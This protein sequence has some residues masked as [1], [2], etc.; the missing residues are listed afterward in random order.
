[1]LKSS[2]TGIAVLVTAGLLGA[3]QVAS[4]KDFNAN[5]FF[6]DQ[7]PLGK[8]GYVEWAKSLD[9]LSN[10]N[11]KAKVYTGTVLLPPRSSLKGVQDGI[12][13]VGYHAAT[14]TPAELP[15]SNA[16]Q[17]MGLN[18]SDPLVMIAAATDFNMNNAAAKK[19]WDKAGVVYGGGYS[20]PPYSLMCNA[21]IKSLADLKGKR[22]R[23][24]GAAMSRW[25]ESIGAVPVNVPS[26]EMYQGIEKGVLDCAVNVASDLKSRS[27]WDVAKH[28]TLAP[29]GLYWS[30]PM[31]AYNKSFWNDLSA[32]E[33]TIFFNAAAK[34]MAN[35]YV[36]YSSA[37]NT[38]LSEAKSHGVTVYQPG[39]DVLESIKSFA[40]ENLSQVYKTGSEKYGVKDAET[41]LG[42]FDETVK[43]WEKLFADVDRKDAAAIEA[44]IKANIYDRIDVKAYGGQS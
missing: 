13:S 28:T 4:A 32:E 18:Y 15:I 33:R 39:T 6:P 40:N 2:K 10:G 41:V 5:I 44:I 9:T 37:V 20:T 8:H 27:L 14:Y 42:Q 25:V 11:L 30:G 3:G 35:L 17:E 7:H 29:L 12:V 23:T 36:G 1:M 19:Q 31:W 16:I 34:A 21:P 43:K 24:A 38:A 22:L 26:S